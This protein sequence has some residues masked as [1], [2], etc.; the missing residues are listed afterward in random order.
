VSTDLGVTCSPKS[1]INILHEIHNST[2][3]LVFFWFRFG[4]CFEWQLCKTGYQLALMNCLKYML[5][6]RRAEMIRSLVSYSRED[7]ISAQIPSVIIP[8]TPTWIIQQGWRAV[9][10]NNKIEN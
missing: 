8:R 10:T 2:A 1:K 4:Y 3:K 7:Q 9:K 6:D 5:I